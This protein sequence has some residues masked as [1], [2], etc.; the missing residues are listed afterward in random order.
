MNKRLW[1]IAGY[2]TGLLLSIV[3]IEAAFMINSALYQIVR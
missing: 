2:I 1:Q 3:I